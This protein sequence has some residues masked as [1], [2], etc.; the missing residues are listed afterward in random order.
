MQVWR[1]LRYNWSGGTI[2]SRFAFY[3]GSFST[4]LRILRHHQRY[5]RCDP[6]QLLLSGHQVIAFSRSHKS[7]AGSSQQ[8]AVSSQQ[9]DNTRPC[10]DLPLSSAPAHKTPTRPHHAPEALQSPPSALNTKSTPPA[11]S[12]HNPSREQAEHP[13]Q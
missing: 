1:G 13:N 4:S 9:S 10:P 12:A 5:L 7:S 3:H 2:S 6:L 11:L 8:S